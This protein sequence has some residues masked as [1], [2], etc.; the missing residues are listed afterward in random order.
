MGGNKNGKIIVNNV[1]EIIGSETI[2]I[3]SLN[4]CN[5]E[6]EGSEEGPP[7]PAAIRNEK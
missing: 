4:D 6:L 1:K 5:I 7:P 3:N 2:L